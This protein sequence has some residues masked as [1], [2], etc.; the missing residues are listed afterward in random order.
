MAD[1]DDIIDP[2]DLDSIDALLDEAELD[3]GDLEDIEPELPSAVPETAEQ[4]TAAIE[5]VEIEPQIA[6]A[7]QETE[8]ELV[9]EGQEL[10]AYAAP[11][12]EL[13]E[14]LIAD[15]VVAAAAG[16]AAATAINQDK[17]PEASPE[18]DDIEKEL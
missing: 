16:A 2:N 6:P 17:A 13:Q 7:V 5:E 9:S 18:Q 14:D 8:D 10:Q 4:E 15:E 1:P 12:Q 11:E 3:A